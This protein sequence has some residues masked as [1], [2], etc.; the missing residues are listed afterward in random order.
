MICVPDSTV[1]GPV[2]LLGE[3][4][5]QIAGGGPLRVSP[6]SPMLSSR[7]VSPYSV[8]H[9]APVPSPA[10]VTLTLPSKS[11]FVHM[12]KHQETMYSVMT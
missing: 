6:I 2:I 12:C 9:S 8:V 3:N 5:E 7:F 10:P 1:V 4:Y 11:R